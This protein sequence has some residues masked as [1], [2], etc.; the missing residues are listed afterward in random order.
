MSVQYPFGYGLSYTSFS[1]TL[2]SVT[3]A[4]GVI[5][6]SATVTNTGDVAG[7]DVVGSLLQPAPIPTAALRKLPPT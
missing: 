2:N 5:T 3:E 1:Q 6:V 4:D 7:K